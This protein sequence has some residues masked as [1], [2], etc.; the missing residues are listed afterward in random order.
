ML[1]KMPTL[2]GVKNSIFSLDIFLLLTLMD[3][4]DFSFNLF[5]IQ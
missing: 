1:T 2:D 4:E 3:M 5:M